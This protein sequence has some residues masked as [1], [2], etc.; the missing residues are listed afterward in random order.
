MSILIFQGALKKT[1]TI[2]TYSFYALSDVSL[3]TFLLFVQRVGQ[4]IL[5]TGPAEP[6]TAARFPLASQA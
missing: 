6:L 4:L 5:N 2:S 3:A 1:I